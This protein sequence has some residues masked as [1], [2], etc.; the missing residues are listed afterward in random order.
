MT[1]YSTR[2]GT[3]KPNRERAI[4]RPLTVTPIIEDPISGMPC[5]PGQQYQAG[6]AVYPD[7]DPDQSGIFPDG[8]PLNRGQNK[9]SRYVFVW[10][11]WGK[12]TACRIG[13]ENLSSID[14]TKK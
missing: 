13:V 2:S 8:T 1:V 11:T 10:K 3:P 4:E 6:Q 7:Q 9:K 14:Q 12:I 5:A